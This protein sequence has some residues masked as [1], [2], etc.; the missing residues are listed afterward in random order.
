MYY[1]HRKLDYIEEKPSSL[2]I[3]ITISQ[4]AFPADKGE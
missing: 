1:F 4:L 2:L 3:M